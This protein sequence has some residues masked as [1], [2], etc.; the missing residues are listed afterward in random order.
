[1]MQY[2][3]LTRKP[4]P[5][6][7]ERTTDHMSQLPTAIIYHLPQHVG[8]CAPMVARTCLTTAFVQLVL[9]PIAFGMEL[10]ADMMIM[11]GTIFYLH[12]GRQ[13]NSSSFRY[14]GIHVVRW[15][16]RMRLCSRSNLAI[17]KL[18]TYAAKTGTSS[19]IGRLVRC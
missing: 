5:T 12:K 18:I 1:M 13:G 17:S 2:L 3:W 8:A 19:N 14:V 7:Y 9:A 6:N 10:I 4:S 11:L 15:I 16:S